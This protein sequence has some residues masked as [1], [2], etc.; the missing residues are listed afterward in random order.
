MVVGS[1]MAQFAL[2]VRKFWLIWRIT[3]IGKHRVTAIRGQ[4]LL[5]VLSLLLSMIAVRTAQAQ[6]EPVLYNF[7]A[8]VGDGSVPSSRLTS[9]G[10]GNFYGTTRG[11]GW[12][13]SGGTVFEL[14]PNGSGGWNETVLY[15]FCSAPNCADGA[16][17]YS[18]VIF[19]HAGNLYGTAYDGGAPGCYT[20]LSCGVVFEL[21]PAEGGSWTESVL[22]TFP[23]DE[24]NGFWP[25]GDLIMDAAGN[26]YGTTSAG[27]TGL[28]NGTVFELSPSG[29]SWTYQVLYSPPST[30]GY[31]T[32]AGLTMD[33]AGN[34][35]GASWTTVFEVSPDGK[36]NW[37]PKVIHTFTVT[38]K[39]GYQ[40]Y[41]TLA[42]DKAGN[43]YGTTYSGGSKNDG[44]VYKLSPVT[45]GKKKGTWT[46]K[47]LYSFK[48]A[49]KDGASPVA[50]VV[51]DA[52]GDIYGT[53][54]LGGKY[55]GYGTVFEL[56]APVGNGSYK[57]RVLWNFNGSDGA[58]PSGGLILD[59]AGN[60]YGTTAKGGTNGDGVVFEVTP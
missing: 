41:G 49:K 43:L 4:I 12:G 59:S 51:L 39:D 9:D 37:N 25:V 52:A 53:T 27:G 7:G 6:T 58:A 46:E 14:S 50:G 1:K 44:T 48:G 20:G 17:P 38:P 10:A 40:A 29:G 31:G 36:G 22:Y 55:S 5:A 11:Q 8:Q 16:N 57:E 47:I 34:L 2:Y 23:N 21:S 26:L 24:T 13:G 45:K 28:S 42:L 32:Y 18:G 19:D 33:S 3:M 35:F 30:T 15:V 56:V 54:N 60:L